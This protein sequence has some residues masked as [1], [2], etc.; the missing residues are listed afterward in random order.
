MPDLGHT[1]VVLL[2]LGVILTAL[3]LTVVTLAGWRMVRRVRRHP[4]ASVVR[5]G[6]RATRLLPDLIPPERVRTGV[7]TVRAV[8]ARPGTPRRIAGLRR[9]LNTAFSDTKQLCAA[10]D[11]AGYRTAGLHASLRDLG[12]AARELDSDLAGILRE[13]DPARR[14]RD[15]AVV[16]P[17][18][19]ELT[20]AAAEVRSELRRTAAE[21][22][23]RRITEAAA[24]LH[25]QVEAL[26][27]YRSAYRS[28]TSLTSLTRR[29]RV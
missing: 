28:L 20:S 22:R 25:E 15:L 7:H 29:S 12:R 27:A 3:C 21:T 2:T 13:P 16:E 17:Q 10:A 9:D 14:A 11:R 23:T 5:A 19:H 8:T 6:W 4:A 26:A 1:V 18:I 24:D